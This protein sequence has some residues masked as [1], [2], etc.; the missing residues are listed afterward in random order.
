[1]VRAITDNLEEKLNEF[2]GTNAIIMQKGFIEW[3]YLIEKVKY[4]IEYETLTIAGKECT[5]Y[6]KIN[7][8]Q[9]YNIDKSEKEIKFYLDNDLNITIK[10]KIDL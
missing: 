6:L 9:I 4:S 8:N 1:M 3:E 10:K 7:L 2:K 5:N